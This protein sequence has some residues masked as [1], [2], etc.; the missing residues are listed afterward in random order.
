MILLLGHVT[1]TQATLRVLAAA[2]AGAAFGLEREIRGRPAGLRTTMITTFA[3]A[4]AMIFAEQAL[5]DSASRFAQGLITGIGFLGAGTITRHES[6]VHGLTTAAVVW[7]ATIIGMTFGAGLW[8]LGVLSLALTLLI[9][10]P[11][12]ACEKWLPREWHGTFVIT[13]QLAGITDAEI[14]QRLEA[15][16]VKVKHVCLEYDLEAK[17]RTL[18]CDIK[19]RKQHL[20]QVAEQVMTDLTHARG[21]LSASW[22]Q[23]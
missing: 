10:L 22:E 8:S 16:H 13:V 17:Q 1:F 4:A 18:R 15:A 2:G 19:H 7:T 20:F 14:K 23:E 5:G 6:L 21:V 9:L 3:A 11:L 12:R